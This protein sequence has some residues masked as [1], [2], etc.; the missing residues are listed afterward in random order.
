[1]I[2]ASDDDL[3]RAAIRGEFSGDAHGVRAGDAFEQ[4]STCTSSLIALP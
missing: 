1:V 3:Q 4:R 2:G